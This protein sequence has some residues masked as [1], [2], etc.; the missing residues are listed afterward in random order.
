[1]NLLIKET[2]LFD[3]KGIK[4]TIQLDYKRG[5]VSFTEQDSKPKNYKFAERT[6]NYLGGWW[7]IL[8][9]LQEATKFA[10][11]K[12]KEQEELREKIKTQKVIDMAIALSDLNKKEK[13]K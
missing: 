2:I 7:L 1:M 4:V 10:D 8:E 5:T 12:L 6:R 3:Y 11:E 9:A 13:K